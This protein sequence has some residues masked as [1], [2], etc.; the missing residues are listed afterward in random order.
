MEIRL[1]TLTPLWTGGIK[2]GKMDRLHETGIIGSLRWWYEAIVRGL[3]GSVCDPTSSKCQAQSHCVACELFG[4]T[5]WKRKFRLVLD[6]SQDD[7]SMNEGLHP[8]VELAMQLIELKPLTDEEKWL[9]AKSVEIIC[10][11]G[12]IGGKKTLKPQKHKKF[13]QDFGLVALE[14]NIDFA[15][16][17]IDRVEAFCQNLRFQVEG[18]HDWPNLNWFFFVQG[19]VLWRKQMNTLM[20]LT[21]NGKPL[22]DNERT[23]LQKFLGS[24]QPGVSKKIFSFRE[25]GGRIWGYVDDQQKL[26][27]VKK[28]LTEQHKIPEESILDGSQLIQQMVVTT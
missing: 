13:G 2:S 20:G 24:T 25:A 12:A 10:N 14:K 17:P 22:P 9:L 7:L 21:E 6:Y 11:H 18:T 3:G 4:C 8:E 1:R 27:E 26:D 16:L 28:Q 19:H 15:G 23:E 5:G